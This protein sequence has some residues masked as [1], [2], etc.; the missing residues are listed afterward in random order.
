[1]L[2]PLG[3]VCDGGENTKGV[4]DEL[5]KIKNRIDIL[6]NHDQWFLEWMHQK[7]PGNVWL[8][9]GGKATL[10][11]YG[12]KYFGEDPTLDKIPKEH[13][14]FFENL[15]P[16][17]E[18]SD[19]IYVHGG[20]SITKGIEKTSINDAIWDRELLNVEYARQKTGNGPLWTGKLICVGH[21]CTQVVSYN[22]KPI[23]TPNVI[24]L[25]TGAGHG[26]K[27]TIME[28][29]SRKYCQSTLPNIKIIRR[30]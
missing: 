13:K 16:W 22:D 24:G 18:D 28:L 9:Q 14:M 1:M 2:I 30:M 25:D 27:L 5:L 4:V 26:E 20:F 6:G 17:Y 12:Y 21:S 23:L 11:S 29:P 3:D 15:K 7:S 10:R 8:M 19:A